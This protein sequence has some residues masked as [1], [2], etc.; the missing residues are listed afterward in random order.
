MPGNHLKV[1]AYFKTIKHSFM[2]FETLKE[3]CA[4]H[5]YNSSII[6]TS[7]LVAMLSLEKMLKTGK[8][9]KY[10]ESYN[11]MRNMLYS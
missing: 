11:E 9:T 10:H 8:M 7:G 5:C 3:K 1:R 6:D 4:N 2:L